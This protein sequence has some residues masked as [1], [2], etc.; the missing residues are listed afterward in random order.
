MN[1]ENNKIIV[2]HFVD[3]HNRQDLKKLGE[4]LAPDFKAHL[5]GMDQPLNREGYLQGVRIAHQAFSNLIFTIQDL[6]AEGEKVVAKIQAQ[7]KHTGEYMGIKPTGN[8]VT[9]K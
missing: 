5:T 8:L 9:V 1:T 4:L 7:G 6:I 3:A 2:K